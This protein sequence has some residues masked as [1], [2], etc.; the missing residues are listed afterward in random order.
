MKLTEL[1]IKNYKSLGDIVFSPSNFS[2]II[3][4]NAS[5]K[6]NFASAISFLTEVYQYGLVKAIS[7]KGGFE[8]IAYKKIKRTKSPIEFSIKIKIDYE[9]LDNLR[10]FIKFEKN[11]DLLYIEFEHIF[12]FSTNKLNAKSDYSVIFESVKYS[13]VFSDHRND[14]ISFEK[15]YNDVKSKYGKNLGKVFENFKS[16]FNKIPLRPQS[17]MIT[18]FPMLEI[19][20]GNVLSYL[21]SFRIY[22]F[23]PFKTR[24]PGIYSPIPILNQD[25]ENLPI[26]VNWF[27]EEHPSLWINLL[28]TMRDII[29]GL[30]DIKVDFLHN[31]TLGLFFIEKGIGKPWISE[32]VSDGTILTL[33]ILLGISDPNKEFILIEEPENS[34]H[35]WILRKLVEY[36]LKIADTK[37]VVV[38]T[39][40][41]ILI[42]M[43]SPDQIWCVYKMDNKSNIKKITELDKMLESDWKNGKTKISDYLDMGLIPQAVLNEYSKP[44]VQKDK[45]IKE[46][47]R[48][49]KKIKK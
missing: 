45:I 3:G 28:N 39:H 40:S 11:V 23:N 35:P 36:F 7:V 30:Q 15:N 43:L 4:P 10:A 27:K 29:P 25:G 6:S 8:N 47:K 32:E 44:E 12:A 42:D 17:L 16:Y 19:I 24:I 20:F 5:G 49:Y 48:I 9:E 1:K 37:T 13:E 31:R 22:Q 41:L 14:I 33:S 2:A 34:I 46:S 21:K 38:T 18:D 26:Y